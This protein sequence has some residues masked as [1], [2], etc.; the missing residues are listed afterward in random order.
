MALFVWCNPSGVGWVITH[1]L[2]VPA[3]GISGLCTAMLLC[4][5]DTVLRLQ[6]L[7]LKVS[8]WGNLRPQGCFIKVIKRQREYS[9]LSEAFNTLRGG[10]AGFI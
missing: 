5:P 3:A 2:W 1:L 8:P 9:G 6:Q 10:K 4:K 7:L